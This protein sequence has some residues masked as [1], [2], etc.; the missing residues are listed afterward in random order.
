MSSGAYSKRKSKNQIYIQ[1]QVQECLLF[2]VEKCKVCP[3]QEFLRRGKS[4]TYSVAIK[5]EEHLDQQAFQETEE[6]KRLTRERYK[7]EEKIVSKHRYDRAS[8]VGLFGMQ[9]QEATPIFLINLKI[10]KL[11]NEEE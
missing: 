1:E 4:K 11:L 6:F 9:I 3:L 2:D 5:S 10:L 8:T 7:I